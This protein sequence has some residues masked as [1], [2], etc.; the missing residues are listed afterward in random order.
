MRVHEVA[1]E[2][3]DGATSEEELS[4]DAEEESLE[5]SS[6]SDSD[7]LEEED[8]EDEDPEDDSVDVTLEFYDP[9]EADF[10]G[11]KALLQSFLDGQTY[12]CSELVDTIINQV[13][14]RFASRIGPVIISATHSLPLQNFIAAG[15]F[16]AI[17]L[18]KGMSRSRGLDIWMLSQPL[19]INRLRACSHG[20]MTLTSPEPGQHDAINQCN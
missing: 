6:D 20:Y 16:L 1:L 11:L 12:A 5:D 17:L 19:P 15:A 8:D 2:E 9:K 3:N 13:I 14:T 10:H 4:H 18:T 7:N